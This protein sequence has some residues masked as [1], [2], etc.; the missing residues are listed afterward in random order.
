VKNQ[1]KVNNFSFCR[2]IFDILLNLGFVEQL[3]RQNQNRHLSRDDST[4]DFLLYIFDSIDLL[5]TTNI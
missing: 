3:S 5:R 1:R 4:L 2:L